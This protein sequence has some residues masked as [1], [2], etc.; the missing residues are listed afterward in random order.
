MRGYK[1]SQRLCLASLCRQGLLIRGY[2]LGAICQGLSVRG[3]LSG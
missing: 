2:L 1:N 3:Y